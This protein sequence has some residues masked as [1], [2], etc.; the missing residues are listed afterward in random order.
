[1]PRLPRRSQGGGHGPQGLDP[2]CL[3]HAE[4]CTD[5]IMVNG[6]DI[7]D[8]LW[9]SS[10]RH[11]SAGEDSA[12]IPAIPGVQVTGETKQAEPESCS[13]SLRARN[14]QQALGKLLQRINEPSA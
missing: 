5:F 10:I 13:A 2:T 3:S 8:D 11:A 14:W 12:P 1:M 9:T 7:K 4:A 6:N